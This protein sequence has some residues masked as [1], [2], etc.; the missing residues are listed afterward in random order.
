VKSQA[1]PAREPR[2]VRVAQAA[3]SAVDGVDAAGNFAIQ[4]AAL[5]SE[6]GAIYEVERI[7]KRYGSEL[8]GR[9]PSVKILATSDGGTLYKIVAEPYQRGEATAICELLKTKGLDC[10]LISR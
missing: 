3:T 5:R 2:P 8:G 10:M 9:S 4:F 6:D 7:A 1:K